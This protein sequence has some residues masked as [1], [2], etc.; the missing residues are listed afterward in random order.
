MVSGT[1]SRTPTTSARS[2]SDLDLDLEALAEV[3]GRRGQEHKHTAVG[4]ASILD[5]LGRHLRDL[6]DALGQRV[7]EMC[8]QDDPLR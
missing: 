2:P 5:E 6:D 7:V 1:A 8:Q 4:V 3:S